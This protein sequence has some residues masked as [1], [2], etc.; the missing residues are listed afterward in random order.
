MGSYLSSASAPERMLEGGVPASERRVLIALDGSPGAQKAFNFWANAPGSRN[1]E[2]ILFS[3]LE[4]PNVLTGLL[5]L[6]SGTF[7]YD[8][9]DKRFRAVRR[10]AEQLRQSML[11]E[12]RQRGLRCKFITSSDSSSPGAAIVE[13]AK[14]MGVNVVVVGCRGNN[15]IRRS[16]LGSVS[17]YVLQ[18]SARPIVVVPTKTD[19]D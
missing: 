5:L 8:E 17:D 18:H 3:S 10:R 6:P 7:E 14:R 13:A 4:M 12:C 16:I 19:S 2:L 11:V 9:Y 15:G 1:D